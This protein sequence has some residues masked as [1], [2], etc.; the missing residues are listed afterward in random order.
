MTPQTAQS[1]NLSTSTMWKLF[2]SVLGTTTIIGGGFFCNTLL[3]EIRDIKVTLKEMGFEQKTV[4][5][6]LSRVETK[7]D[8]ARD[9]AIQRVFPNI[10]EKK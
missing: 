4:G 10:M 9:A 3:N 7:V 2:A 1:Q 5:E 6:R 8:L